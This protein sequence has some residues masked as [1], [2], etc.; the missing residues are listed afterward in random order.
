MSGDDQMNVIRHD[1][2][3][4]ND[5]AR[6]RDT[7]AQSSRDSAGLQ[8]VEHGRIAHDRLLGGATYPMIAWIARE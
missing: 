1:G 7:R 8:S 2:A 6:P 3:G 5:E 4:V